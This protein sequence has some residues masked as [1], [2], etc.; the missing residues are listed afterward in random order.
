MTVAACAA[1]RTTADRCPGN[2]ALHRAQDGL[3]ARVRIPGGRLSSAQLEALAHAASL[4]SG[5]VELTSRAN[6]Q[7][8][9]L[10][11]DGGER[12]AEIMRAAGLLRSVAHDRVRNVIASPLAGRHP[13]SRASTDDVVGRLD[14]ALCADPALAG[15]P[16]RILFTVDD[17]SGIAHDP[18]ADIALIARRPDNYSLVIAGWPAQATL[19][20]AQAVSYSIRAAAAFLAECRERGSGAWRIG[21]LPDGPS[22]IARRIGVALEPDAPA[23]PETRLVPGVVTQR[24][25]RLAV[26][27]LARL[28]RLNH[29]QVAELATLVGELRVGVGRTVTVLDLD[30]AGARRMRSSLERLGLITEPA[31][32]WTGLTAC[33]GYGRCVQARSDLSGAIEA[34]ASARRPD[35]EPEHWAACERRCGERAGQPVALALTEHGIAVRSSDR[36][37]VTD[38]LDAGLALLDGGPR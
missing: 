37:L 18:R 14:E 36:D 33:A 32:G 8:R 3:L 31:S 30:P 6:V 35:A 4:G 11:T 1:E 16:G 17:G 2:L 27:G 12:L 5:L 7:L 22:A 29:E 25:G 24:D 9:G 34:R 19:S 28:G 21:E 26:T 15:L 23:P 13:A 10:P 20:A 38:T